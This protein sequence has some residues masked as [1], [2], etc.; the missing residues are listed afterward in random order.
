MEEIESSL[1]F[2][3]LIG[4]L[5]I[6]VSSLGIIGNLLTIV[7]RPKNANRAGNLVLSLAT[8]DLVFLIC[9]FLLF[10]IPLVSEKFRQHHRKDIL[11][12]L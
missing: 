8:F 3:K 6:V 2:E 4:S 12:F 9:A 11:P 1:I 5:L 7:H 10:G